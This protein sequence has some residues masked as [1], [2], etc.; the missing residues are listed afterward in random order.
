MKKMIFFLVLSLMLT[1]HAMKRGEP[2]QEPVQDPTI[3]LINPSTAEGYLSGMPAEIKVHIM[4][5]FSK[6]QTLREAA[7][8]LSQL[9]QVNKEYNAVINNAQNTKNL[10]AM[11]VAKFGGTREDIARAVKTS[12]AQRYLEANIDDFSS[13]RWSNVRGVE[14]AKQLFENAYFDVHYDNSF[15]GNLLRNTIDRTL[16]LPFEPHSLSQGIAYH[17]VNFLIE[18]GANVNTTM[19]AGKTD[20]MTFLI[21]A[22]RTRNL[23]IART[24]MNHMDPALIN[25]RSPL[26]GKTA[27]IYEVSGAD[28][29]GL[30]EKELGALGSMKELVD[31]GADVSIKDET[32]QTA[33]DYARKDVV[34]LDA[35]EDTED[36]ALLYAKDQ[37]ALILKYLEEAQAKQEAE[38][39]AA[40]KGAEKE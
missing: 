25:F 32:G 1:S 20:P 9:A 21:Y 3:P 17:L 40:Q 29:L 28:L 8:A 18:R 16:M 4:M 33:I 2:D 23:V 14:D 7:Q 15:Q 22:I 38:K 10:I 26:T 31:K 34:A 6:A 35:E 24:I 27:L 37:A 30:H 36:E 11:L 13:L 5:M 39:N 19:A 12:G